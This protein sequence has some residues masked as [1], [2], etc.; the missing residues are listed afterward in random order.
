[1]K[2]DYHTSKRLIMF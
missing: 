2:S 1:M